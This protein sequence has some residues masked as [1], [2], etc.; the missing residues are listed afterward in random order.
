MAIDYSYVFAAIPV[1][2]GAT[3]LMD[4]WAHFLLRA[5]KI[6]LPSYCLVGRWLRHMPSGTFKHANIAAAQKM[7]GECATGWIFH[8]LVGV[9]YAL[10]PAI[11]TAG[12]WLE[13]PTPLPALIVGV[14]TVVIPFFV[15]QPAMGHG[16]AAAKSPNPAQAR[17]RSLMSHT[18]F[19]VGLYVSALVFSRVG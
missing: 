8:Y 16:I 10:I 5:F 3:L 6:P 19:G 2:V 15:M 7:P 1:G 17:L 14:G 4:L 9:A 11:A 18:A 13:Q 12:T